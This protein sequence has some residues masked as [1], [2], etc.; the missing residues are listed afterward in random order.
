MLKFSR[1]D[2]LRTAAAFSAPAIPGC[3]SLPSASGRGEHL[4]R[5]GYVMTMDPKLGNLADADVH[6]RNGEIVA[7]GKSLAAPGAEVIDGRDM[8]VLPG[9][10]ETHW[11]V[12]NSLLRG[13]SGM[14][15]ETGYFP[16]SVNFSK[17]YTPEDM[18]QAARFACAEALWG[19]VT[20][21]HDQCH[22]VRNPA[23]AEASLRGFR[24]MNIRAR[25]A[26]GFFWGM[27]ITQTIDLA[28][29]RRLHGSWEKYSNDGLL[30]LGIFW[31][32]PI[33]G[34][35]AVPAAVYREEYA[36]CKQLNIPMSMHIASTSDR[37][38]QVELLDKENLLGKDVLLIHGLGFTPAEVRAVAR[39]DS[40]VSIAPTS[41]MRM[42]YGMP[43]IPELLDAG[44]TVAL[45]VDSVAITGNLDFFGIMKIVHDIAHTKMK[46]E[47]A[48]PAQKVIEMA[49]IGGARALNLDHRIG[50]LTPGKRADVIM[51]STRHPN[52]GVFTDPAQLIVQAASPENVDTVMVDGRIV[53][54][55]GR[56]ASIDM[57]N[58]IS[59]AR[60][61][62]AGIRQRAGWR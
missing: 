24:D 41:E 40:R 7:V 27:P 56:F 58:I 26:Y 47:T 23:Y 10:V 9:L 1:R 19:G 30:D 17:V 38:G 61:S 32:G 21:L 31:R 4:I 8:I 22:N 14:S 55:G 6:V 3:A 13:F 49:T 48:L 45:S 29:L 5:G 44:V 33:F 18:Y 43:L 46:S 60:A 57:G 20:T 37:H 54:S 2:F 11:H 52:M 62:L 42:G 59:G 28:D 16:T 53:K 50:S 35:T 15:K 34:T 51:V 36:V 12:W 39:T 25:F